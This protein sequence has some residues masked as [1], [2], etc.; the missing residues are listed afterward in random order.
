MLFTSAGASRLLEKVRSATQGVTVEVYV[1]AGDLVS[2]GQL[3]GH[4]ELEATRLQ[5]DLARH[6]M[7]SKANVDAAQSQAEAWSVTRAE[8]E[9]AV[10]KRDMNESRLDWAIAMERM[11]QAN[12]E[13]Q[14][15][16]ETVQ[17][18]QYDYWERQYQNRFF[19]A[20]VEG[21]VSEVLTEPGKPVNFGAHLFT[22]RNDNIFALPV[23]V[24]AE[25]AAAAVPN[26]TLPVR[27][28]DGRSVGRA[29]I[30]S[31]IDDPRATG[32]KIIKLLLKAA[33]VPVATRA[34]LM[35]M[36][37]DVLL[38]QLAHGSDR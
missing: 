18:I 25:L 11:Y 2:K 28:A 32:G 14:T 30:D 17:K 38:P 27:S 9:E 37:F 26:R 8:T 7:D 1:K 21:V 29:L 3:L 15:D 35:G 5:L 19:R 20:P 13:V 31:V 16:A 4:T 6:T 33:D 24:P 10:R 36:K 34:K 22:I 23:T 12:H